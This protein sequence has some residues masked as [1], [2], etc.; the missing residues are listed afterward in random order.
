MPVAPVRTHLLQE[1]TLFATAAVPAEG[2]G[3][4]RIRIISAGVGSSGVYPAETLRA[5]AE[6]NV[7]AAGT[8]MYLDH[9]T[10]SETW[11]RPE[12]SVRDLAAVFV[13][14]AVYVDEDGGALDVDIEVFSAW[15]QTIAEMLKTIGV[16]IR[17]TAEGSESDAQ[18]RPIIARIIEAQSVDFVTKAGRGGKILALIESAR[19]VGRAVARGV[20]EATAN[21]RRDQLE[22]LVR[23]AYGQEKSWTWVRDFDDTTVWFDVDGGDQPGTY[24]QGYETTDDVATAL[25]GERTE[26]RVQTSYVP[27]IAA[28]SG[29][30][31]V[32]ASPAGQST[33]TE[34][35]EDTMATIPVEERELATLKADAGRAPVLES[36][37]DA[38]IKE[39]DEAKQALA[40]HEARTKLRPAAAAVIN[41][42]ESLPPVIR[43]RVTDQVVEAIEPDATAETVKAA[44][45]AARTNAEAEAAAI[46]EMYGVGRPRGLGG[47]PTPS[48]QGTVSEAD[49]DQA[50]A[51]AFG[52]KIAKEA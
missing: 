39:R 11:E 12:R 31:S 41:A 30:T 29:P 8:H 24:S 49:V 20:A 15:R 26:V 52:R 50:V 13:S 48:G 21:D 6:A 9:P 10:E 3:R 44:A 2:P 51:S 45:E 7:F 25:T 18:G 42:S 23:D 46:A 22:T 28:E 16:S 37:R 19:S 36:E 40:L 34:S 38:A 27:V 33:A 43:Q 47:D 5:A 35:K 1:S 17:A 32:P 14:D 4:F